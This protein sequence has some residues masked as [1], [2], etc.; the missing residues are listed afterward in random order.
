[1]NKQKQ[2]REINE[3]HQIFYIVAAVAIIATIWLIRQLFNSPQLFDEW[4]GI[5]FSDV[6][7]NIMMVL[8]GVLIA[9]FLATCIGAM[10]HYYHKKSIL[11]NY[12]YLRILPHIQTQFDTE[13]ITHM[14]NQLGGTEHRWIQRILR[15]R[16]WFRFFVY[17]DKNEQ[18]SFYIGFPIHRT[19]DV[20]Q[21]IQSCYKNAELHSIPLTELPFPS[22]EKKG[23]GGYFK[24]LKNQKGLP[25][26]AI[27]KDHL[28]DI[29][30]SMGKESYIDI[31]FTPTSTRKLSR[32]IKKARQHMLKNDMRKFQL[33]GMERDLL[34]RLEKR[35]L[36]HQKVFKVR[37]SLWSRSKTSVHTIANQVSSMVRLGN[38]F[39]IKETRKCPIRDKTPLPDI[40]TSTVLFT[41]KELS[42]FI[43]LPEG[44][45][46]K[47]EKEITTSHHIYD[48]ILHLNSAQRTLK[49]WELSKGTRL[50]EWVHPIYKRDIRIDWEQLTK[51]FLLTGAPGMGKSSLLIEFID[52]IIKDW[53]KDPENHPGFT[54]IDPARETISIIENRLAY[55]EKQGMKIPKHKIKHFN[56]TDDTTH[57]IA[58]NLLYKTKGHSLEKVAKYTAEV[59]LGTAKS[60]NLTQSKR[61]LQ[62]AIWALLEDTEQHTIL[63]IEDLFTNSKFRKK[64]LQNIK[65]PYVKRFWDSIDDDK[66]YKSKIEAILNR[67]DPLL[68]NKSMRRMYCQF[69]MA[70]DI[71]KYMDDGC[72]VFVDILGM[73]DQE[74]KIIVGHMITQYHLVAQKRPIGSKH[75]IMMIDEAHRTQIPIIA[76]IIAEDRKFNFGIGLITQEVKQIKDAKLLNSLNLI[77]TIMSCAQGQGAEHIEKMTDSYFTRSMISRLP[78]RQAAIFTRSKHEGKSH[79]TTCIIQNEP[80]IVYLPNGKVANYLNR[81]KGIAQEWGYKWGLEIMKEQ[82]EVTDIKE[83]DQMIMRYM[84][85]TSKT[86]ITPEPLNIKGTQIKEEKIL[87]KSIMMEAL[88]TPLKNSQA[89]PLFVYASTM[90]S[91]EQLGQLMN[92]DKKLILNSISKM[93]KKGKMIISHYKEKSKPRMYSLGKDGKKVVE[94]F[95]GKEITLY[96]NKNTQLAHYWGINEVFIRLFK[97]I[98]HEEALE[99]L[100]WYNT[101]DATRMMYQLWEEKVGIQLKNEDKKKY[102]DEKKRLPKPD[103]LLIIDEK[104]YWIEYDNGTEWKDLLVDRYKKYI[105]Y[106]GQIKNE[107]IILWF[108]DQETRRG[109]MEEKWK[110]FIKGGENK[111]NM[112]F[113]TL[114]EVRNLL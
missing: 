48:Y 104:H 9:L 75:H 24:P 112:K 54:L 12:H 7:W 39:I 99:R 46:V 77:G 91:A 64:V 80:P 102:H 37:V 79:I 96:E 38:D 27:T 45:T 50:G 25:Y 107:E 32:K 81:E 101:K 14:V 111:P 13:A 34:N 98:G 4:L 90:I 113:L 33:E 28:S 57:T 3:L 51:H 67:L 109:Y 20:K 71:R 74:I 8:N 1:M 62:M 69:E 60:D 89:I 41:D 22:Q 17:R 100:L 56:L 36:K 68:S 11:K 43:H 78:E 105:K 31:L 61:L 52:G 88:K 15:G 53:L 59:I 58:L 44:K 106:M 16:E 47:E 114:D 108:T 70:L 55:Y 87:D 10:L 21:I 40:F 72:I 35:L 23:Y 30:L 84:E 49:D 110:E 2:S 19:N 92:K 97:E 93:N 86:E 42:N 85:S 94:E 18:I 103:A 73:S 83:V 65:D 29:L 95:I 76:N 26:Q 63:G 6:V 5:S 66:D 82:K